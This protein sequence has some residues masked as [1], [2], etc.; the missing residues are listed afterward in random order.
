[1]T[2]RRLLICDDRAAARR[3][4]AKSPEAQDSPLA[5]VRWV[6]D[7]FALVDE[8]G[9]H[10]ADI[11]LIGLRGDPSAGLAAVDLIL[12]MYP[13]APVVVYGSRQQ[14]HWM[15]QAISQGARGL[16]LWDPLQPS[17][18]RAA[19]IEP[20]SASAVVAHSHGPA[21]SADE[22]R[23]LQGM[24]H[25][26]SNQ[27]IG[28]ALNQSEDRVKSGARRM[29]GKLCARD[30]AHAV[31]Q[32]FRL[33]YLTGSE[34]APTQPAPVVIGAGQLSDRPGSRPLSAQDVR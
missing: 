13:A 21:L 19:W 15:A 11:V 33:G 10:R 1:M 32:A 26:M 23:V 9:L 34:P 12:G 2:V 28:F 4:S 31:A 7:G 24:S 8:F 14:S 18:T 30:R 22:L 6:G 25:G 20:G 5:P 3:C 17:A 16:T 27:E 29:F